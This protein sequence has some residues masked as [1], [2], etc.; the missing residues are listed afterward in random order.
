MLVWLL[1]L[2]TSGQSWELPAA[3]EASGGGREPGGALCDSSPWSP[4]SEPGL[5]WFLNEGADGTISALSIQ[6]GR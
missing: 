2:P 4:F 1:Q 3:G 5:A 6:A